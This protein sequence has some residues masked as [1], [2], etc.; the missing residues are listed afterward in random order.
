M[1]DIQGPQPDPVRRPPQAKGAPQMTGPLVTVTETPE[2]FSWLRWIDRGNTVLAVVG[3]VATVGL[4]LNIVADVIGRFFF[5][6]PL[7]G[8]LDLTQFAWMPMLISLGL[9]YALLR[10]EHIR[11]NLLTAPT[12]ERTQRVIEI[13]AMVFTIVTVAML[14]WFGIEKADDAMG[15]GEKA[16]GT[17][18]LVIWPF[19]WI[20]VVGLVGLLLQAVA[21]LIRAI[22]VAEFRPADEDEAIAALEVEETVFDELQITD[23]TVPGPDDA[24]TSPATT[25]KV[26]TP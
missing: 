17:Q 7:P 20:I 4:M 2:R 22:V 10:G 11:V 15:F 25:V 19:R 18:W 3:G 5:N 13:V 8:T 1:T 14:I 23:P 16:V 24:G 12:G 6:H 21:Q 9:G 26:R